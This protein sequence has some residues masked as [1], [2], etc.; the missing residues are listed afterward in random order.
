MAVAARRLQRGS[1][2]YR[3]LWHTPEDGKRY[4]IIDEEVCVTPPSYTAH[5]RVS[6]NLFVAVSGTRDSSRRGLGGKEVTA[7]PLWTVWKWKR[8]NAL[9]VRR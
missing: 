7:F 5:Q 1:L 6:R 8:S 3:D 2:T 4:D 9:L